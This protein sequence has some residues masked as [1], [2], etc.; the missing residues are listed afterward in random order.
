LRRALY[1]RVKSGAVRFPP[2]PTA[3]VCIP[4]FFRDIASKLAWG[5][6]WRHIGIDR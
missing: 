1:G 4:D 3:R 2:E 5:D 6:A